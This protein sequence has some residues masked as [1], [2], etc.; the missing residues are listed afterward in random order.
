MKTTTRLTFAL[1]FAAAVVGTVGAAH[2]AGPTGTTA[3]YGQLVNNG[4]NDRTID[5][6]ANTKY[7]N[8]E[9]GET[10][11]FVTQGQHFT[12]H[13]DTFPNQSEFKLQS[14]AP[15]GVNV[16]NTEVYVASNP[17]YRG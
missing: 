8:V 7:V 2:A 17:L 14:I 1:T 9:D 3:D 10:V 11:Q 15:A 6:D 5:L 12:W 16:G 4:I 13:F